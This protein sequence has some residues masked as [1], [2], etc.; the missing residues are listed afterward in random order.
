MNYFPKLEAIATRQVVTI[1]AS[2]SIQDA[3]HQ[4]YAHNIRDVIVI[5]GD[6]HTI[7]TPRELIDLKLKGMDFATPLNEVYLNDVPVMSP[8]DHVNDAL[9]VLKNHPDKHVCLLDEAGKLTGIVSYSD[10]LANLDPET[11]ARTRTIA[12]FLQAQSAEFVPVD[13]PIEEVFARLHRHHDSAAI[14]G[15]AKTPLGIITQSEIIALLEEDTHWRQP[16]SDFMNQPLKTLPGDTSVK[17]ALNFARQHRIKHLVVTHGDEI[18]GVLHQSVIVSTVFE[19][20]Y[21]RLH[22]EALRLR[23][24]VDM[25][26]AGPV[27]VFVWAAKDGWPVRFVTPNVEAVLGY[28]PNELMSEKRPYSELVHP[29]DYA[30]VETEVIQF[31][32]QQKPHWEQHYRLIDKTGRARWFF[33]YTRP[34]YDQAGEVREIH[35][36][37]LDQTDLIDA[38][39]DLKNAEARWR[40]VLEGTRQGVWDWDARTDRV[41]FSPRWKQMLG[42]EED[43]IDSSL[44]EWDKRVHPDDKAQVYADL[45]R[46]FAGETEFYENTHRVQTKSGRYIWVLDRGRVMERDAEGKPLRVVGTHTDVDREHEAEERL[47]RLAENVPGVLYQF[48]LYP[49]GGSHFPFATTGIESIYGVTAQQAKESADAVFQAI[50]SDDRG[51]VEQSIRH[52]AETLTE[53]QQEYRVRL[54]SGDIIWVI[55]QA[56]P[57]KLDDGSIL[58]HGYIFDITER[59]REQLAL[60][61]AQNRYRL[62]MEAAQTGLWSWDLLTDNIVW[63]DEMFTQLGYAPQAFAVT[64]DR[65]ASMVHPEDRDRMFAQVQQQIEQL[66]SFTQQF[67]VQHQSGGWT[68]IEG[69]GRN[70][71]FDDSGQPIKM[72][73]THT[74]IDEQKRTQQALEESEAHFR[75]LFEMYPDATVLFDTE[76]HR[77]VRF[78]RRAHEQ[79]G[80]S[81]DE[82]AQLSISDF[83]VLETPE[84]VAGHVKA[85]RE[86]GYDDFET[87]HRCKNGDLL[88]IHVTVKLIDIQGDAHLLSVF[89]DI[90]QIKTYQAELEAAKKAAESANQAKSDFL[91]NMSHEIRTPMNGIIGM[92][93]LGEA[94]EDAD[95]LKGYLHQVNHSGRQLLGIINDILDFSKIEAGKLLIDPVPFSLKEMAANLRSLFAP[96]AIDKGLELDVRVSEQ[97]AGAY[98]SDGMRLRQVLTN[99]IGNAIKFTASGRVTLTIE[100]E[101]SQVPQIEETP[102]VRFWVEDTGIGLTESQKGILFQPFQQADVS[103]TRSHGGTGLGLVISQRLVQALGGESIEVHSVYGEGSQIGFSLPMT[104]CGADQLEAERSQDD[105]HVTT[106]QGHVLLVED[107]AINQ[108]VAQAQLT[109]LGLTCELAENGREAVEKGRSGR[110]DLVLMDIQMPEMDGYEATRRLRELGFDGQSLPIVA[111]TAAAMVEDRRKALSHGMNDHVGKPLQLN[112]LYDSLSA[113]LPAAD[114]P[115]AE[116]ATASDESERDMT[117]P[118]EAPTMAQ[119]EFDSMPVVDEA[120]GL[121]NL[122]GNRQLYEK[123]L[124]EVALQFRQNYHTLVADLKAMAPQ[125]R[126]AIDAAQQLN[127]SLKGVAGNLALTRLFEASKSV[128]Q[129]LK[130]AQV[131]TAQEMAWLASAFAATEQALQ[132]RAASNLTATEAGEELDARDLSEAS[133]GSPFLSQPTRRKLQTLLAQI[134]QN[135]FLEEA[136]IETFFE[137]VSGPEIESLKADLVSWLDDL[138][139]GQ[140]ARALKAFLDADKTSQAE[141]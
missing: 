136:D 21:E 1:D 2:R 59:K 38:Q 92:S 19:S 137:G 84:E 54:P 18:Q 34:V 93:E 141:T 41:F 4:M 60:E 97:L 115:D 91:A 45:N 42:Y 32:Q 129:R 6:H 106:L 3:V 63:T 89:R 98:D 94:T 35:G 40:A 111:L 37:L 56:V 70:T 17:D 44:E 62:T 81:A 65:F 140:A 36:Y 29:D 96:M 120:R 11:L 126:T 100:P 66:G 86:N 30:D 7:I 107:N 117:K 82:F 61:E 22:Q 116:M 8:Q 103:T 5:D 71:E 52:S 24:E 95:K 75:T 79:L 87:Q 104:P 128:D 9:T 26:A 101:T 20:W 33:D 123:L 10:L 112:S 15:T 47:F 46:H 110:F 124:Q 119:S 135:E 13:L 108:Q 121:A 14:V 76:T 68:W 77:P 50:H 74:Q 102:L 83:E 113:F 131:P 67:R 118:E 64:L 125:D 72:M 105:Q 27:V 57:Q 28:T 139:F 31:L 127:H 130:S 25:F 114:D 138:E 90:T 80:Y 85:I 55:G 53:W 51:S 48:R 133:E 73:G 109:R 16:V 58:W 39:S 12:Q 23:T 78:N 69:R 132:E 99:L 88:D 43:E 134:E 122:N 49:D